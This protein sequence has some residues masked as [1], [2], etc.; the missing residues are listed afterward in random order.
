MVAGSSLVAVIAYISKALWLSCFAKSC[1][2]IF[3]VQTE[4]YITRGLLSMIHDLF[5]LNNKFTS[6]GNY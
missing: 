2:P 5:K 6:A 1:S 4:S 3:G